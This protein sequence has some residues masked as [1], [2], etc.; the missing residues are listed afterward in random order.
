MDVL[1]KDE[2]FK[3]SGASQSQKENKSEQDQNARYTAV[4][5]VIGMMI[6]GPFGAVIGALEGYIVSKTKND[7]SRKTNPNKNYSYEDDYSF[8]VKYPS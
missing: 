7:H 1:K 6:A 3:M 8:N 4:G 5:G 2:L